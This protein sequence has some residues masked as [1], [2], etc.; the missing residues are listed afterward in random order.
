MNTARTQCAFGPGTN[1]EASRTGQ[2]TRPRASAAA[3]R[4]KLSGLIVAAGVA[5][6]S[7]SFA[8]ATSWLYAGGGISLAEE[9]E[10]N[11]PNSDESEQ[12]ATSRLK[13]ASHSLLQLDVGLGVP[14]NRAFVWGGLARM[15]VHGDAGVDLG[16]VVR[17]T[18]GEFARGGFG[19]GVD[20]G[21]LR[22][23]WAHGSTAATASLVL[24]A[25]WGITASAG[26]TF[27]I[28]GNELESQERTLQI[29]LGIDFARL[30]VHRTTG[31]NWFPNPLPAPALD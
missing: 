3:M 1:T 12:S 19:V 17:G 14:A 2:R 16:F 5:T 13:S 4:L 24:G 9:L 20:V 10:E 31:L 27:P 28:G 22:R 11:S 15:L 8:Q 25:P 29:S 21:V 6:S 7:T 30:T 23:W 18:T 26:A